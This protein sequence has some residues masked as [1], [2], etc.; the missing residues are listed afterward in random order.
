MSIVARLVWDR[1][2]I[3][4]QGIARTGHPDMTGPI[5]GDD[6]V[7]PVLSLPIS[8]LHRR[9][10]PDGR[11]FPDHRS[12]FYRIGSADTRRQGIRF[13][14]DTIVIFVIPCHDTGFD[15]FIL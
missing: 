5:H 11:I 9:R 12:M 6:A 14:F 7:A 13:D 3:W 10:L 1:L 2:Q 8:H 15:R 4:L